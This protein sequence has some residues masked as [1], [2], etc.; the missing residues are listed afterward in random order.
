[1]QALSLDQP[2]L[3][4]HA[5]RQ[6]HQALVEGMFVPGQK[7]SIRRIAAALGTSPMPARTAL[8]RLVAERALDVLPSGTAIVPS[9]TRPAFAEL[10]AIRAELEPLAVRLAA[11]SVDAALR[12]EL[13]EI[14]LAED[15]A[16]RTSDP[17]AMLKAERHFLFTLYRA[18]CAPMLLGMIE[19]AWLRRGPHFWDARWLLLSRVPGAVRHSD[20]LTALVAGDGVASATVLKAEIEDTTGFLLERMRFVDDPPGEPGLAALKRRPSAKSH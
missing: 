19:S 15:A 9:L 13:E 7:L 8:N 10:G 16:R 12:G 20:I 3:E 17:E 1:M 5:Y 14:V 6:L 2:S 11:P 4:E 18:A